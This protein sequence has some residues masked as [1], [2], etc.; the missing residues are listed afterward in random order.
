MPGEAFWDGL[1]VA[2]EGTAPAAAGDFRHVANHR[3]EP[4]GITE[5]CDG[6]VASAMRLHSA[7]HVI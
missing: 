6:K 4:C 1:R 2:R 5:A 3:D 7:W